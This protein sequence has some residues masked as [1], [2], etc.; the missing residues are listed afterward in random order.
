MSRNIHKGIDIYIYIYAKLGLISDKLAMINGGKEKMNE[1]FTG[2][3]EQPAQLTP[4]MQ[5]L[6]DMAGQMGKTGEQAEIGDKYY[7]RAEALRDSWIES[8]R[9]KLR[10]AQETTP[11]GMVVC[12]PNE[13]FREGRLITK[14]LDKNNAKDMEIFE[15][16]KNGKIMRAEEDLRRDENFDLDEIV[17]CF[18][19]QEIIE[20]IAD[21][22]KN[23]ESFTKDE[24][25]FLGEAPD[26]I[27][28]YFDMYKF[29]A[30]DF[31]D[32][33]RGGAP[34]EVPRYRDLLASEMNYSGAI[35]AK[36]QMREASRQDENAHPAEK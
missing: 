22:L 6:A 26:S 23:N 36:A 17:G 21:K 12:M 7:E 15:E 18:K 3:S 28:D 9:E 8:S 35:V 1:T 5:S 13:S 31:L 30:L 16:V 20:Q 33:V 10:E 14:L 25:E 24:K 32:L 4:E 34:I 11:D 29:A 27:D 2:N 19:N